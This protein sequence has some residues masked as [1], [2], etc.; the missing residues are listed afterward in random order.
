MA[1]LLRIRIQ[2]GYYPGRTSVQSGPNSAADAAR[3][4]VVPGHEG[5]AAS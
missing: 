5:V 4:R 3:R 1:D 2:P